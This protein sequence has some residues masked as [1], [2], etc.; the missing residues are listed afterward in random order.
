M[1]TPWTIYWITRASSISNTLTAVTAVLGI[2]GAFLMVGGAV[3]DSLGE[4]EDA[5]GL[6]RVGWKVAILFAISL[7]A[8][9]L[10]PTTK[11]LAS[12][13]VIPKVANSESVQQLGD[14]IVDLA[15]QWLVELAPKKKGKKEEGK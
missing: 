2:I 4:R 11:E 10:T 6:L 5:K 12:M 3:A 8:S 1:I 14:G 13:I 15:N 7:V 9:I